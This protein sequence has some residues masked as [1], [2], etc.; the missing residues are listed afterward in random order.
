VKMLQSLYSRAS[1]EVIESF[2]N[3]D[4]WATGQ[5]VEDRAF[6]SVN[7]ALANT[8]INKRLYHGTRFSLALNLVLTTGL[9]ETNED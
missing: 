9:H 4:T 2:S 6:E 8:A 3:I 7:N 5:M 1:S